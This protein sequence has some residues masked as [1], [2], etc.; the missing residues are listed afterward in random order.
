MAHALNRF[1]SFFTRRVFARLLST[2]LCCL[3]LVVKPLSRFGGP[4]AFLLLTLKELVFSAQETLAQHFEATVLNIT[5]ALFG[6]GFSTLAR[7]IASLRPDSS[8]SSRAIP[9]ISLVSIAFLGK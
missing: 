9:A 6:I 2:F 8:I 3:V 7:Y 1:S 4:S 5:G